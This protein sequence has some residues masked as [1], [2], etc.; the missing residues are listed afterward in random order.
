MKI[1]FSNPPW[2]G[3]QDWQEFKD[4]NTGEKKRE[5]RYYQGV[6]AGSRWPSM[7]LGQ[8]SPDNFVYKDYIPFPYFMAYAASY[9]KYHTNFD[10]VLR[11]SIARKES[12]QTY[13]EYL[14]TEKFDFIFIETST[15]SLEYDKQIIKQ[16]QSILPKTKIVLTGTIIATKAQQLLDELEIYAVIKGEYDKNSLKVLNNQEGIIEYDI[17]TQKEINEAPLPYYEKEIMFN[18]YNN[19]PLGQ[20]YPHAHIFSSRG[21]PYKC[22]FCAWPATLTSNDI[23]GNG[24]RNI[25]YY[26]KDYMFKYVKFLVE[27]GYKSILFDDDTFNLGDKHTLEMCEV[28][29][30]FNIP[31]SAMCRIDTISLDTWKKMKESGCFGVSIGFESGSQYV[32]DNIVNKHLDLKKAQETLKYIKKLGFTIHGTFTFGLPGETKAQMQ[33]TIEFIKNNPFDTYQTSGCA[34]I[35]GTPLGELLSQKSLNKFKGANINDEFDIEI[36]GKVKWK[37]I[38]SKLGITK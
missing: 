27:S 32:I 13:Y 21:C 15:P 34:V 23:D 30:E 20:K 5:Y 38:S 8:S 35:D 16:I 11:D 37:K 24:I 33:E 28:M 31:W 10:V 22:I 18:Y 1:L 29:K 2:W 6:R 3:K 36:D 9:V 12:L 7:Y 19:R 17:L 25:R 26:D 14:K 4:W